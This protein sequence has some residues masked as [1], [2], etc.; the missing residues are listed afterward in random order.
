MEVHKH[1]VYHLGFMIE[2]VEVELVGELLAKGLDRDLQSQ[3][4]DKIA[5]LP[6]R[7]CRLVLH[8]IFE[9]GLLVVLLAMSG[10][11]VVGFFGHLRLRLSKPA[12]R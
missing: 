5:E 12:M 10:V 2:A 1:G 11:V 8:L 9:D 3:F 6:L 4:V 7:N